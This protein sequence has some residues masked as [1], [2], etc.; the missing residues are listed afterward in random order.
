MGIL[1]W[2]T[3]KNRTTDQFLLC[4]AA[5]TLVLWLFGVPRLNSYGKNESAR[6]RGREARGK[7]EDADSD[8]ELTIAPIP[9][10]RAGSMTVTDFFE[11]FRD[12]PVIVEVGI[13]IFLLSSSL[14]CFGQAN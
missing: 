11:K 1:R 3:Y 5:L 4:F 10:I 8:S 9:R 2:P 12:K 13:G 6:G 14:F 7:G